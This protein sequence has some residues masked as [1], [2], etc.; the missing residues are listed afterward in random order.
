VRCG[1]YLHSSGTTLS[2]VNNG[3]GSGTLSLCRKAITEHED[4]KAAEAAAGTISL[5]GLP[6]A[7]VKQPNFSAPVAVSVA[8]A[9]AV[10]VAEAET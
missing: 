9:V 4:R 5:V 6:F 7:G 10:A 3:T 2:K 1:I 8:V